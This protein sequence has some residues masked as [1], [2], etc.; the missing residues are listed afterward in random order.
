MCSPLLECESNRIHHPILSEVSESYQQYQIDEI[1]HSAVG[2]DARERVGMELLRKLLFARDHPNQRTPNSGKLQP[3]PAPDCLQRLHHDVGDSHIQVKP[4]EDPCVHPSFNVSVRPTH[5]FEERRFVLKWEDQ[6]TTTGSSTKATDASRGPTVGG[7]VC[8]QRHAAERVLP[9]SG[10]ELQHTGSP[11]EEAAMEE[12]EEKSPRG[13]LVGTSGIG[14]QETA[15][16]RNARGPGGR[17]LGGAR[18]LPARLL[19]GRSA[20]RASGRP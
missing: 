10:F 15:D 6:R 2:R 20:P 9:Q 13:R 11:S 4:R 17:S 5:L 8:E 3:V 7:G 19:P 18:R 12:E 14:H 1:L 16:H